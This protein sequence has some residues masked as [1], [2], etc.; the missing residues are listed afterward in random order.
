MQITLFPASF[1]SRT[2]PRLVELLLFVA[3]FARVRSGQTAVPRPVEDF[4]EEK[5][6]R[7]PL[8]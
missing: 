4:T 2:I 3:A 8:N 7:K 5:L 1:T 6:G